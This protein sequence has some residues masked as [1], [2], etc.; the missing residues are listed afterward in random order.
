MKTDNERLKKSKDKQDAKKPKKLIH[1]LDETNDYDEVLAWFNRKIDKYPHSVDIHSKDACGLTNPLIYTCSRGLDTFARRLIDLGADVHASDNFGLNALFYAIARGLSE[2]TYELIK[3]DVAS[4]FEN[5]ESL[6]QP[7]SYH[8]YGHYFSNDSGHDHH[9]S[10]FGY[11]IYFYLKINQIG[12]CC[13]KNYE[14]N[15][16][17]LATHLGTSLPKIESFL[18]DYQIMC[19]F[20]E[21]I[22]KRQTTKQQFLTQ[23][24]QKMKDL[25][26][27]LSEKELLVSATQS[28]L[29]LE[30]CGS[31]PSSHI[32]K[33]QKL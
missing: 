28:S 7:N 20:F 30:G 32:H 22:L 33:V 5:I 16:D 27:I 6:T 24:H 15:I 1:K 3:R 18:R 29:T 23:V 9:L 10:I 11:S 21:M 26:Q 25:H 31:M 2:V 12:N 8:P 14:K 13:K 19:E 17:F 4:D